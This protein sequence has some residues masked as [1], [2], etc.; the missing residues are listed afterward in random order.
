MQLGFNN[1]GA[2]FM[3]DSATNPTPGQ[4]GILQSA[5]LDLSAD[6]EPD[7]I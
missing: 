1:F 6:T 2:A 4:L 3:I 7:A 5:S